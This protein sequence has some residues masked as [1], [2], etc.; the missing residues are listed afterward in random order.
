MSVLPSK[1]LMARVYM[2]KVTPENIETLKS[3]APFLLRVDLPLGSSFV[4][5]TSI[6][7]LVDMLGMSGGGGPPGFGYVINPDEKTT[8]KHLLMTSLPEQAFFY[9]PTGLKVTL[10]ERGVIQCMGMLLMCFEWYGEDID[11][12]E[13][14]FSAAG[15]VI[16]DAQPYEVPAMLTVIQLQKMAQQQAQ[17][18]AAQ[19]KS[20]G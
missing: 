15:A 5:A 3:D 19:G 2:P 4:S 12:L 6:P 20:P 1:R 18:A 11:E 16:L 14:G 13:R 17:N 9:P 10:V 7:S 8:T